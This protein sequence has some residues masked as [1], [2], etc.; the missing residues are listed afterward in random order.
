MKYGKLGQ[1][2]LVKVPCALVKRRKAHFINLTV[3]ASIILACN[4][5][6]WISSVKSATEEEIESGG[7][8]LHTE[9]SLNSSRLQHFV[10]IYYFLGSRARLSQQLE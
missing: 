7:Y 8:V 6:V 4:G 9:V 10:K 5:Y 3:G 2:I 1:G